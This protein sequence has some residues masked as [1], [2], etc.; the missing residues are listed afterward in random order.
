MFGERQGVDNRDVGI[1]GSHLTPHGGDCLAGAG[2]RS[3]V[4]GQSHFGTVD[5]PE[6]HVDERKRC[7]SKVFV[8]AIFDLADHREP[9]APSVN[10]ATDRIASSKEAAD[11]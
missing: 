4:E 5:L 10:L 2:A 6:G 3:S 8:F 7:L 11:E 1:D 9:F